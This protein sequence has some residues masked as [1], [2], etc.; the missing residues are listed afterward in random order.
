MVALRED[1]TVPGHPAGMVP[2]VDL[3]LCLG[4]FYHANILETRV[5]ALARAHRRREFAP[6]RREFKPSNKGEGG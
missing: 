1:G 6:W 2:A 3:L 5:T 4:Y